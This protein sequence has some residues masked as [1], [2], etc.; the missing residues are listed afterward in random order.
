M[1]DQVQEW[2]YYTKGPLALSGTLPLPQ[3]SQEILPVPQKVRFTLCLP[4]C[5]LLQ[6]HRLSSRD[7]R[8]QTPGG[9]RKVTVPSSTISTKYTRPYFPGNVRPLLSVCFPSL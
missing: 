4:K 8:P 3:A 5:E 9:A 1:K 2:H 6:Q 7:L